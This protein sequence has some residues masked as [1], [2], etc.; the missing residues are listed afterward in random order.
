MKRRAHDLDRQARM[1][2]ALSRCS[3]PA[4]AGSA[5]TPDYLTAY[6]LVDLTALQ[7][8]TATI[9]GN[10]RDLSTTVFVVNADCRRLMPNIEKS[11][12]RSVKYGRPVPCADAQETPA[13]ALRK[14]CVSVRT[15]S[16][17]PITTAVTYGD[18]IPSNLRG[19]TSSYRWIFSLPNCHRIRRNCDRMFDD[20][21]NATIH[22]SIPSP[23]ESRLD[24]RRLSSWVRRR[25]Q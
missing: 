4:T 6:A 13:S 1:H 15:R 10:S 19:A 9:R 22:D 17:S 3:P 25:S 18:R 11:W 16:E 2:A 5:P 14:R 24:R 12:R 7:P 20:A 21:V 8:L 23:G